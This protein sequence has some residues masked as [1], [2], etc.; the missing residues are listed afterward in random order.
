MILSRSTQKL[1]HEKQSPADGRGLFLGGFCVPTCYRRDITVVNS[2]CQRYLS[3]LI[4]YRLALLQVL[5]PKLLSLVEPAGVRDHNRFWRSSSSRAVG[6]ID[7]GRLVGLCVTTVFD[8]QCCVRQLRKRQKTFH[9]WKKAQGTL[10]GGLLFASVVSPH[11]SNVRELL[12][13]SL[14]KLQTQ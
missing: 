12:T 13:H 6:C 7:K 3:S 2:C 1:S 10:L 9:P 14:F 8:G 11:H 5:F 4:A